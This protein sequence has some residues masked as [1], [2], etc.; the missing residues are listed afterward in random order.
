[1]YIFY[2]VVVNIELITNVQ[3]Y[4]FIILS[5]FFIKQEGDATRARLTIGVVMVHGCNT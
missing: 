4:L 2:K 1:M 3:I 5:Y